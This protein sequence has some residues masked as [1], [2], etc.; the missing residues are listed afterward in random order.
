MP[1]DTG[2]AF[3]DDGTA[4]LAAELAALGMDVEHQWVD[5]EWQYAMVPARR[6]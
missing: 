5:E 1:V 6:R 4:Q 3:R 2:G